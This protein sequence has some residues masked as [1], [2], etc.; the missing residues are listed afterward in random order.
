MGTFKFSDLPVTAIRPGVERRIA[1]TD[2]LMLV[3]FDFSDG[4]QTQPDPPHKHPHEQVSYVAR[5]VILFFLGSEAPVHL[6]PG[7]GYTVPADV[8]HCIQLLTPRA[9]LVDAFTPLREDFLGK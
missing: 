1:Y 7:D 2:H 5:G 6:K 3:I 8:P 9:R 4:P